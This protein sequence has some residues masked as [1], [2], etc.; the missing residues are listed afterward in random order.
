MRGKGTIT[1][2]YG[3]K[4]LVLSRGGENVGVVLL[5]EGLAEKRGGRRNVWC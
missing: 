1:D 5:A 2:S 3:R 4:L